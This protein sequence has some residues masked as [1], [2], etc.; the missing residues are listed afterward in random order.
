MSLTATSR[1]NFLVIV[2][3]DLGFSDIGAFGG[4]IKTP[5]LDTLAHQGLRFTDFHTASACSPTRAMLLTGT[6]HHLAGLGQM[7]EFLARVPAYQ[8]KPG[9]EGHLNDRVVTISELLKEAGY[10]TVM[11]GKWHLGCTPE[12]LPTRKGFVKSFAL[13]PG[14]A[15]HYNYE[16]Q[17]TPKKKKSLF[18][19]ATSFY[20]EDEN[21]IKDLPENFYSSDYFTDRL[22]EFLGTEQSSDKARPFFAY[23]PYSA[24]HW[25]LQAPKEIADSYKGKYD[26]GPETLRQKRLSRLKELNLVAADVEPH[27]VIAATAEWDK[28]DEADKT[29]AARKMEVYAAMVERMDWNIGR[30]IT[31]LKETNQHDNTVIVFLSDNGAEGNLIEALPVLGQE[32][33]KAITSNNYDNSTD[34]IG[35]ANS[36]VWYGPRWA[37]AATAPGRLYKA[38]TSEGGIRTPAFIHYPS[39]K[40]QSSIS[41]SYANVMDITPT[42]LDLANVPHPGTSYQGRTINKPLGHSWLNYLQENDESIHPRDHIT[43][44]ELFGQKAIRQ[45]EWK[46]I[47]IRQIFL[48][49][50]WQLY[51]IEKDPGETND[52]AKSEP[53]RLKILLEHWRQYAESTGVV[54][55][56]W[57]RFFQFFWFNVKRKFALRT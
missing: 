12:T 31:W 3:D 25:P 24:P 8:G 9:H 52:L 1:P 15:N 27:P 50:K 56:K 37:Q 17:L 18:G 51:N 47:S 57:H 36:Y 49:P 20:A 43:G 41:H 7:D 22:L 29:L 10:F 54:E 5:N 21:Y 19:T 39:F 23:L 34:N 30:V 4:E 16:P 33:T 14:A 32:V 28:L 53:E 45:G 40:R 42:L 55:V 46:A 11:S 13:L 6:D 35:R 38:Y 48:R 44:W 2:A 26:D